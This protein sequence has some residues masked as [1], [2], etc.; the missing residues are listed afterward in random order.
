MSLG[1]RPAPFCKTP[2]PPKDLDNTRLSAVNVTLAAKYSE[3]S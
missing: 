2:T 1:S 3:P